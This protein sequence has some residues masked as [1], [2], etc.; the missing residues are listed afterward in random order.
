MVYQDK[1]L[2]T[3]LVNLPMVVHIVHSGIG[4][5][6]GV[7]LVDFGW[8]KKQQCSVG[9]FITCISVPPLGIIFDCVLLN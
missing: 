5:K 1:S 8:F 7:K 2:Q 9:V 6:L 4:R 3:K